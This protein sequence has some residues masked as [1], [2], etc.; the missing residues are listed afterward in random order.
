MTYDI[1][2]TAAAER[3]LLR[4]ADHIEFPGASASLL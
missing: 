2:I 3:D 1:H 4:A